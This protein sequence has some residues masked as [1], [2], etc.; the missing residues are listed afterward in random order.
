M[1]NEQILKKAIEKAIKNGYK[2]PFAKD[3]IWKDETLFGYT[4]WAVVIFS[5]DFAKAFWKEKGRFEGKVIRNGDF[6]M[7]GR[8]QDWQF[9]LAQMVISEDPIK[10]LGDNIWKTRICRPAASL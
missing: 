4:W 2:F 5:H 6:M 3:F 9:Y 10:Y 7:V 8:F 1:T